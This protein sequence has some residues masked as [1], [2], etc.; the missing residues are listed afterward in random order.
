M[1][2][3]LACLIVVEEQIA[4][5]SWISAPYNTGDSITCDGNKINYSGVD[6]S[7]AQTNH[8]ITYAFH[9][10][11]IG[12]KIKR[13]EGNLGVTFG[14]QFGNDIQRCGYITWKY[15]GC[16]SDKNGIMTDLHFEHF[17]EN[18]LIELFFSKITIGEE[19]FKCVKFVKNKQYLGSCVIE[20]TILNPFIT[21]TP[22][23]KNKVM[24]EVDTFFE[25]ETSFNPKGIFN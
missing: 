4:D 18:D 15:D 5:L 20:G 6:S 10:F 9:N 1:I 22:L 13:L 24:A 21:F 19:N 23:Q 25:N 8:A 11:Y 14:F 17:K 7:V 16:I 3:N 12:A 2:L